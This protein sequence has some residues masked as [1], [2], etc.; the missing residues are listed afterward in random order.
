MVARTPGFRPRAR[1]RARPLPCLPGLLPRRGAPPASGSAAE[2]VAGTGRTVYV[3]RVSG[4]DLWRADDV[5][6]AARPVTWRGRLAKI[7]VVAVSYRERSVLSP[8]LGQASFERVPEAHQ[9][10]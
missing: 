4:Y 1:A 8:Q 6:V 5:A 10:I 7:A 2:L 9:V 3:E